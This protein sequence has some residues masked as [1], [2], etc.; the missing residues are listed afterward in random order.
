[1]NENIVKI[2]QE[3]RKIRGWS[4]DKLAEEAGISQ[5]TVSRLEDG[6]DVSLDSLRKIY[7]ALGLPFL[8]DI[9][10]REQLL[11]IATTLKTRS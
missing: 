4:Q 9:Y 3:E 1:M 10:T 11:L 2:V 6:K 8:L 7:Q 5:P